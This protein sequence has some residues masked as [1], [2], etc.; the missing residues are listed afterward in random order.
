MSEHNAAEQH[1]P[2]PVDEL[3]REQIR[4][5][6]RELSGREFTD[7]QAARLILA[8]FLYLRGSLNG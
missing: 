1:A 7:V 5:W 8:K 3:R 4:R 6:R 2:R